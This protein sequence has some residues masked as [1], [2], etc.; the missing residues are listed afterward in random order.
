M[1]RNHI[2]KLCSR[3]HT[4]LDSCRRTGLQ[5]DRFLVVGLPTFTFQP[6]KLW[7]LPHLYLPHRLK[8]F[9]TV[10]YV[11]STLENLMLSKC[12]AI[13][14]LYLH[15]NQPKADEMHNI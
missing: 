1:G 13:I 14:H 2:T 7:L 4:T 12:E 3:N 9:K 10:I 11:E 6:S 8:E 15:S 5:A